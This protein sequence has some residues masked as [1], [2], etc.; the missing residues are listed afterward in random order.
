[1]EEKANKLFKEWTP[2]KM[3]KVLSNI[4]RTLR[5]IGTTFVQIITCGGIGNG[6]NNKYESFYFTNK[7]F[8][9]HLRGYKNFESCISGSH[10]FA[11]EVYRRGANILC[12]I[13]TRRDYY[14]DAANKSELDELENMLKAETSYTTLEEL[15][16][17]GLFVFI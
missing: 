5:E 13:I 6:I 9:Q 7:A 2:D 17:D 10:A 4:A 11:I 1:M 15:F 16:E 8:N 3:T 14:A 12:H